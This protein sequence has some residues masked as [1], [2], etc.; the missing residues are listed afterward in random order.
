MS[1][2]FRAEF[3]ASINKK[4][5]VPN[6]HFA[7]LVDVLQ[8]HNMCY[9]IKA[10]PRLFLTHVK[11]RGGLLLSPHNVHKNAAG[12]KAAGADLTQLGNAWAT[13]LAD[14][15][16]LRKLMIEKNT[17]LIQR[18][19]GLLAKVNFSE[20]FCSLGCGHTVAF[21]KHAEAGGRTTQKTL[22]QH[23]S[24]LIDLQ[25][26]C[27][28]KNF[29]TMIKE[30]W[31]WNVVY[32]CVDEEFPEFAD[33]AQRALNTRNH[34]SNVVGT[35]SVPVKAFATIQNHFDPVWMCA[36]S[37]FKLGSKVIEK[38][39][40]A[41]SERPGIFVIFSIGETVMLHEACHYGGDPVKANI[42]VEELLRNWS[43]TKADPPIRMQDP[44]STSVPASL[45]LVLKKTKVFSAL[46][47]A[48]SKN[49]QH[50]AD[51][52][53]FRRPDQVRTTDVQIKASAL[54]LV[55]Y[56][57]LNNIVIDSKAARIIDVEKIDGNMISIIPTSKPGSEGDVWDKDAVPNAYF[58][59]KETSTK[60]L[61][62]MTAS[63]IVSQG[64]KIP[65]IKNSC[66]LEPFTKLY[67]YVKPKAASVPLQN[68]IDD[69]DNDD[70]VDDD[71]SKAP[72]KAKATAK[73][74]AVA[75]AKA[76]VPPAKR[77]GSQ[78]MPLAKKAKK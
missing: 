48:H 58:W 27:S 10:Q 3:R 28:N 40:E 71:E 73:S 41:S 38:G 69:D 53:Y 26:L 4:D 76:S 8:S 25:K 13:E 44:S 75:K 68:V 31:E 7:A 62:N 29:E 39:I 5:L 11:N 23:G 43:I 63:V 32:A 65:V 64:V 47:Y 61:A 9:S 12:I 1:A 77:G 24:Q 46:L 78:S 52:C 30:G 20:R 50:L 17:S 18:A 59:V 66:A 45:N 22:Q 16:P 70:D 54:T 34:I 60:K 74:K 2:A 36:Q 56:V 49:Q 35:A 21:C 15:G 55:P 67:I 33:I 57:P 6:E 72:S 51:L 42:S 19:D 14:S 37:G